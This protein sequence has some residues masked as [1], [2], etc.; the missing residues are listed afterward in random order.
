M[1]FPVL[2]TNF[3]VPTWKTFPTLQQTYLLTISNFPKP[4]AKTTDF[5][6]PYLLDM[7]LLYE[8]V[9]FG[10]NPY[11]YRWGYLNHQML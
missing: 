9:H 8:S 6:M 11:I 1:D 10:R 4:C 2:D 5:D 7:P 3:G